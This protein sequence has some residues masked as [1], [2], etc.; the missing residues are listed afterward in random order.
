MKKKLFYVSDINNSKSVN[1]SQF[2]ERNS[3]I[4]IN[5]KMNWI[6]HYFVISVLFTA[7]IFTKEYHCV[8]HGV[9][10]GGSESSPCF[11][12]QTAVSLDDFEESKAKLR[13][14]CPHFF[15]NGVGTSN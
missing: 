10:P 7:P 2:V 12:N 4:I 9:C 3:K 11:S 6:S 5:F 8:W 14:R 13:K 1:A 15:E